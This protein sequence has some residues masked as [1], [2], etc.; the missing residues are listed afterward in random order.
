[1]NG[2]RPLRILHCPW[3]V[4]GQSAQLAAAERALGADSRCIVIEETAQGFPADEA[5]APANPGILRREVAR[6]RLLWRA[7]RQAD[8]VHF[9]FGQSCL[10]PNAFPGLGHIN[11]RNPLSIAWRLYGRAVWLK[12]LPLLKAMG[13]TIFVTWQGDDARQHDRSLEL[14]DISIAKELG[15]GYY[16]PGSDGWKRRTI[17]AFARHAD[18]QYALNPDLLHV[19]PPGATHLPYASFDPASVSPAFIDRASTAP[20][21]F[22]H[23]P[24]HR[25][26]KG[27][28]HLLAAVEQLRAEGLAFDLDLVEGLPRAE[29][30]QRYAACDVLV[31]QLLAGWYGGLGVEAMALGKPLVAYLREGDMAFLDP[32]LRAELPVISANPQTIAEV[33]RAIIAMPRHELRAIG[34]RSRAHVERWDN[35]HQVAQRT[36]ADY[37]KARAAKLALAPKSMDHR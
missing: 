17:A 35:P 34:E 16:L 11:W 8:V 21:R 23:A 31:D 30:L 29:A 9:S 3:N 28:H 6:W 24:S 14:F 7:M 20:L 33:L 25:G 19:L 2:K 32:R 1:M 22:A 10:V 15:D 26:A 13:K 5:L 18:G 4:A 37:Q 12:D 27:T 36:L